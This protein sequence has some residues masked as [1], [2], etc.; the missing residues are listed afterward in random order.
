MR[1]S[2][3]PIFFASARSRPGP[4]R[5]ACPRH[6]ELIRSKGDMTMTVDQ[7]TQEII[8]RG[9]GARARAPG[10]C[11][12]ARAPGLAPAR[13]CPCE[14]PAR[15][16]ACAQGRC[17]TRSSPSCCRKFGASPS[18]NRERGSRHVAMAGQPR[19][20]VA[21]CTRGGEEPVALSAVCL[22]ASFGRGAAVLACSCV[23]RGA[24]A[25]PWRLEG[26]CIPA[27]GESCFEK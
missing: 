18:S 11:A 9:R 26:A 2:P 21:L 23:G 27:G 17:R 20:H 6:A 5:A 14:A 13:A 22:C 4:H 10:R 19:A 15:D 12:R 24:A 7:L 25:W 1:R 8:P 16:C 3:A